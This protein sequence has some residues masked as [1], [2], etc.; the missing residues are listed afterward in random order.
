M[1]KAFKTSQIWEN[2]S[3]GGERGGAHASSPWR[4]PHG[5]EAKAP[6]QAPRA[7]G[8]SSQLAAARQHLEEH[9]DDA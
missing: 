8:G 9:V 6:V 4:R 5:G 1:D 3:L 2:L 7:E